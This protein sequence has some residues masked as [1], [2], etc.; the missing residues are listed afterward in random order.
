MQLF[1]VGA[2]KQTNKQIRMQI[3]VFVLRVLAPKRCLV[4]KKTLRKEKAMSALAVRLKYSLASQ[5]FVA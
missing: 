5:S 1:E 2:E 3:R 4:D